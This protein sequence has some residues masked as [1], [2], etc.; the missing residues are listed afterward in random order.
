M[1]PEIPTNNE[2]VV[3]DIKAVINEQSTN[4]DMKNGEPCKAAFT[5]KEVG[6]PDVPNAPREAITTLHLTTDT[7]RPLASFASIKESPDPQTERVTNRFVAQLSADAL[8]FDS[9]QRRP[10]HPAQVLQDK[11]DREIATVEVS[12]ISV[13]DHTRRM[14]NPQIKIITTDTNNET[15]EVQLPEDP[16]E[17]RKLLAAVNSNITRCTNESMLDGNVLQIQGEPTL[18]PDE[19]TGTDSAVAAKTILLD[20]SRKFQQDGLNLM[21][22]ALRE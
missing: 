13:G 18:P 19:S 4:V 6:V 15:E 20:A 22:K 3:T 14:G 21:S 10:D 2:S 8:Y 16:E 17:R 11:E 7:G 5:Y 9:S 1:G 12:M